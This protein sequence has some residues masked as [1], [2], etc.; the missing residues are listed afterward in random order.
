VTINCVISG[1]LIAAASFGLLVHDLSK[2][3]A[4]LVENTTLLAGVI[5]T[6]SAYVVAYED[7]VTAREIIGVAS[8]DPRVVTVAILKPD[9][10]V[11]ARFDRNAAGDPPPASI[12]PRILATGAPAHAYS[13]DALEVTTPVVFEGREIGTVYIRSDLRTLEAVWARD[14]QMAGLM[15]ASGLFVAFLLSVALQRLISSPL[16]R[17][18][19]VAREVTRK[20][21]YD[22]RAERQGDDETGELVTRFNEMLSE[23][24]S[25]DLQLLRQQEELEATVAARTAELVQSNR[26]LVEARDRAMAASRAK[27]EFLANMSHEI[28]T[29]MNGIIGMTDLALDTSLSPEQ[30]DYLE[31]AKSSAEALLAIL[32]DILDLSKVESGK[33]ELESVAFSMP[34][35]L[36]QIVRPFGVSAD[37]KGV[38][39]I[40]HVAPDLPAMVVGDPGRIRQ[41]LSNLIGNA[42]KFTEAG[43]VLVNVSHEPRED[44]DITLQMSISDTGIGIPPEKQ[45]AIFESFTQVDG[46]TTRRFGGTGLGL[47]ISA[48]LAAVMGGRI[49]VESEVNVGST[50]HV[51]LHV[52]VSTEAPPAPPSIDLP[53]IPVLVVDDNA[54][55]R[56]I[57]VEMLTRWGMQPHAVENG[58][59]ALEALDAASRDERSYGLVILDAN[60]PEMDGFQ[61]AHALVGRPS[62]AG[63][64]VMMLT[65]SGEYGDASRCRRLGIAA[66]L[67]KPVRSRELREAIARALAAKPDA[68]GPAQAQALDAPGPVRRARVLLAEDNPVNQRVAMRMLTTRGHDV[69]LVDNGRAAVEAV[70]REEFDVVLMDIQMP[71]MSGLEATAAIR[72]R[73]AETGGYVR[74]IA[75]TAHALMGDRERC[76]EAGM[77]GYLSKPV[78]REQLFEAVEQAAVS[79]PRVTA[80]EAFDAERVLARCSGDVEL[81]RELGQLFLDIFPGQLVKLKT[82]IETG[83]RARLAA[84][85]HALRGSSGTL[86]AGRIAAAADALERFANAGQMDAA[87]A[88]LHQLEV[89]AREF[90]DSLRAYLSKVTA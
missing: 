56:R 34:E 42:V 59:A 15:L 47:S 13:D 6:N 33:L 71:E 41:I 58:T 79:L 84:E 83:D 51:S 18:T 57:F 62:L 43:H 21:R 16:V 65:S 25:R 32:N 10:R 50:F 19:E 14:L 66:Y 28:R 89:A 24:Q 73:E 72:A 77:D 4:N 46:S 11:L 70:A 53:S 80:R 22:L 75:M 60:M 17:L 64:T 48:N 27:S 12:V 87:Q 61:V 39:L 88:H 1:A 5:S 40:C 45:A 23:I 63:A 52:G 67:V 81:L 68:S 7:P 2:E 69:T 37:R 44:G 55:N 35:L 26:A 20:R 36:E 82:A 31:T 3:R 85:A 29:P 74:I 38:E 30:R 78:D 8:V 54:A 9:Q 86:G 90:N 76:I 49:W